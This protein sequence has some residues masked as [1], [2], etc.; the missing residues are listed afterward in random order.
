[1]ITIPENAFWTLITLMIDI[2]V[3][4]ALSLFVYGMIAQAGLREKV[5]ESIEDGDKIAHTQDARNAVALFWAIV[6]AWASVN[7]FIGGL[8]YHRDTNVT[9]AALFG[10]AAVLLALKKL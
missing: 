6:F 2:F 9:A 5:K 4:I 7:A 1:M 10:C 8:I 3:L